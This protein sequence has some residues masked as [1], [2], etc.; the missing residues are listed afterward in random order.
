AAFGPGMT[1]DREPASAA[2][3]LAADAAAGDEDR[4]AGASEAELIGLLCARD[5]I[6]AHAA[7]RKLAAVAELARRNPAPEDE[8]FAA[9]QLACALAESRGRDRAE[10]NR[11]VLVRLGRED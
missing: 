5:R 9:D 1:L 8:E 2:L 6:E 11:L 3:A 10:A 4:F 7:A